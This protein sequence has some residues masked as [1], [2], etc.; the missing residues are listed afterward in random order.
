MNDSSEIPQQVPVT[1]TRQQRR[2]IILLIVIPAIVVIASLMIYL[3]GG[4]YVETD[5][6]YLKATVVPIAAEVSG[7]VTEVLVA[8]NTGVTKGQTLFNLDPEPFELSVAQAHAQL[9]EVRA[10]LAATYASYQEKQASIELARSNYNYA[11]R[12]LQRQRDLKGKNFV[13][14]S[15]LDDL[16]HNVEVTQQQLQVLL[17]DLKKIAATLGGDALAPLEQHPSYLKARANLQEAQLDLRR[18][19]VAAPVD[20]VASKLPKVGQYIHS[21]TM[22]T[23]LVAGDRLWIEANFT[24]TDLTY[25]QPGQR[26]TIHIDTYPDREWH[27]T[28]ES[29][30]PATG[31][32]FSILPAQNAT[33]NWVKVAQR[34][35]VRIALTVPEDAPPLRT[36]L[37]VVVEIDTGHKRRVLGIGL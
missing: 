21:G 2:R 34:V 20:G 3:K 19:T 17:L 32:E 4:R 8:E 14:E 10:Q 24:E 15:T 13:S 25:V 27:G 16:E 5:N 12:E 1:V 7:T 18:T 35:P 23:A 29:I 37:S 11:V 6:A 9:D 22:V 31:S 28:V 26:A 36:G 30:S 33:G